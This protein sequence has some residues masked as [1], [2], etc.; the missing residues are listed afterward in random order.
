L[1]FSEIDIPE[2]ALGFLELGFPQGG[3]RE[4][5]LQGGAQSGAQ[6]RADEPRALLS[7][8]GSGSMRY[9]EG[10]GNEVRDRFFRDAGLDPASVLGLT[11]VHSR[12]VLFPSCAGEH[13]RLAALAS[14]DGGADGIVLRDRSLVASVTVADCMPIWLLDRGS[15]AFGV[16]HSG[17]RG[18]G[19]LGAAVSGLA[20]RFG[21]DPGDMAVIL[22][23]AIGACCYHVPEE[24][25]ASF[26]SEFGAETAGERDGRWFIDLRAAN[27]RLAERLG[28]GSLLS[29]RACTSCDP[30]LGSYRRQGSADFTR[31]VAACGVLPGRSRA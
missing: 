30:R 9:L 2:D 16:L 4:G 29:V 21:S 22:G 18:T 7:L 10:I 27:L 25:A 13:R 19:I 17:W 6:D 15:G 26:A 3:T 12:N 8:S 24:R 23:P 5:R 14:Q 11:L 31:M 28:I 20:S 1:R